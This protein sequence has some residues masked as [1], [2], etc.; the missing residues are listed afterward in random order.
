MKIKTYGPGNTVE[1]Y[2][3]A[4]LPTKV[5]CPSTAKYFFVWLTKYYEIKT[6]HQG[7][8]YEYWDVK[9]YL[10]KP[11]TFKEIREKYENVCNKKN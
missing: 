1:G 7:T 3:F 2:R 9:K 6:C 10:N 8:L 11:L 4:F 5:I